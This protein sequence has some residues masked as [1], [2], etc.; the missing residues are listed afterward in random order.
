MPTPTFMSQLAQVWAARA[1]GDVKISAQHL[2]VTLR[3]TRCAL[4]SSLWH[5]SSELTRNRKW[6]W[7]RRDD[8]LRK[9]HRNPA[10]GGAKAC[11]LV[12]RL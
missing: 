5:P 12:M 1:T 7:I 8:A 4:R 11:C 6:D 2:D 10:P 3:Q 9:D